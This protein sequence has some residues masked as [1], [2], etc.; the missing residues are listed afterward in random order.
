MNDFGGWHVSLTTFRNDGRAVATPVWFARDGDSL[1]V[2]TEAGAGK[3]KRIRR[4]GDVT[5]ATCTMRGRITGAAVPAHAVICDA[6]ESQQIRR[7]IAKRY[8]V[9][10]WLTI[11][12][13][14]WRRGKTGTV[15]L[16]ISF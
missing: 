14:E 7:I 16:R 10:G 12:M 15:G 1:V 11:R 8:N 6:D 5:V 9:V 3:V 2:W 4:N 13:S